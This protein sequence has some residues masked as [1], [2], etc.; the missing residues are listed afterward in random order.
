MKLPIPTMV[1]EIYIV[2]VALFINVRHLADVRLHVGG[3]AAQ[4]KVQQI[5]L[6]ASFD[7][8]EGAFVV[9]IHGI[10]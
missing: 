4:H 7:E 10:V 3:A 6:H 5:L 1:S 9:R 2:L 8:A